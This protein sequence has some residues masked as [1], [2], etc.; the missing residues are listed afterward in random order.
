[1]SATTRR[2]FV[3]AAA[4]GL[5]FAALG[6]V[7]GVAERRAEAQRVEQERAAEL[8]NL[9][10]KES[11]EA[12]R[13]ALTPQQRAAEDAAAAKAE[14][15]RKERLEKLNAE[16]DAI[17]AEKERAARNETARYVHAVRAT[18]AIKLAARNPA[19]VRWDSVLINEDGTIACINYGAENGFGG[20]NR[21]FVVITAS[22][23]YQTAQAW[24]KHCAKKQLYDL[25][26]AIR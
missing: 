4:A 17:K 22:K 9:K 15:D 8:L 12:R 2:I 14:A 1:M 13:A 16:L 7:S 18:Q 6:V 25:K 21:E 20:M 26:H 3:V 10:R 5:A 24:N 19:S 23:A 11:E